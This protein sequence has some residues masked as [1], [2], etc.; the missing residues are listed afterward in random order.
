[1]QPHAA[2]ALHV[3]PRNEDR[4]LAV[5]RTRYAIEHHCGV[6]TSF[7][8]D[9]KDRKITRDQLRAQRIAIGTRR[10]HRDLHARARL[11]EAHAHIDKRSRLSGVLEPHNRLR[12]AGNI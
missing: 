1:M 3:E 8:V 5:V 11:T 4:A 10:L 9:L 7:R 12:L 2:D 6:V